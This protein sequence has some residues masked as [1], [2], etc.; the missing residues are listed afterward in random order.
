MCKYC[1]PSLFVVHLHLHQLSSI[2][3][4]FECDDV[5]QQKVKESISPVYK[6]HLSYQIK[7]YHKLTLSD[8]LMFA[9]DFISISTSCA[10]P[11]FETICRG[12]RPSYGEKN[13]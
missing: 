8:T 9:F 3:L 12:V 2:F 6:M 11:F 13:S 1:I 4:L 7:N 5:L 10:K